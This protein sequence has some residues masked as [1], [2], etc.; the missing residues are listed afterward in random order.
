MNNGAG[1]AAIQT[2]VLILAAWVVASLLV[3]WRAFRW[4]SADILPAKSK[5][6]TSC[7]C[8]VCLCP[9]VDLTLHCSNGFS[10]IVMVFQLKFVLTAIYHLG[11]SPIVTPELR[12][13]FS[14]EFGF[15]S[16]H[17]L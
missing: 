10:R 15:P 3:T 12:D 11:E 13:N 16:C 8:N 5:R 9:A 1:W 2:S 6:E 14:D 17:A 4:Q 7:N